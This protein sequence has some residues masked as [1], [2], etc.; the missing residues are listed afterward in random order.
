[1]VADARRGIENLTT[2][3][4]AAEVVAALRAQLSE[5]LPSAVSAALGPYVVDKAFEGEENISD[6]S[7]AT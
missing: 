1:M 5:R 4:V 6:G 3:Q 7:I 2:E